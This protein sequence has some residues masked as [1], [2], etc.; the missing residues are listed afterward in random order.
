MTPSISHLQCTS[1]CTVLHETR[2]PRYALLL[3][4]CSLATRTTHIDSKRSGVTIVFY[5]LLLPRRMFLL[6]RLSNAIAR[7]VRGHSSSFKGTPMLITRTDGVATLPTYSQIRT[8]D[9]WTAFRP[10]TFVPSSV[11]LSLPADAGRDL[12]LTLSCEWHTESSRA[13]TPV[14]ATRTA[15]VS[16][17]AC[18][19]PSCATACTETARSSTTAA[20]VSEVGVGRKH[21]R[22]SRREGSAIS[23]DAYCAA[24]RRSQ[25]GWAQR[26]RAVGGTTP[27]TPQ[28]LSRWCQ[29]RAERLRV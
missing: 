16:R 13:R 26:A 20:S 19:A 14:R 21:V 15:R 3:Q 7:L 9:S 27:V 8:P 18:F 11:S 4:S 23:T 1:R 29:H 10:S 25:R 5:C 28:S 17:M 22:A 6:G 12:W 24:L 2:R